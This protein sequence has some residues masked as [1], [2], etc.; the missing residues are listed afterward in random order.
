MPEILDKTKPFA[1]IFSHGNL[2]VIAIIFMWNPFRK[3]Y[4]RKLY[5]KKTNEVETKQ[6]DTEE[7]RKKAERRSRGVYAAERYQRS[8]NE[9]EVAEKELAD[10]KDFGMTEAHNL[11]KKYEELKRK[12]GESKLILEEWEVDKGAREPKFEFKQEGTLLETS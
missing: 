3:E 6:S 5:D 11:N 7:W 10:F 8:L 12:V 2:R 1:I 4:S 9:Q